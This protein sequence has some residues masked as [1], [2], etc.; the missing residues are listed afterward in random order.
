M[1]ERAQ[2]E[3]PVPL[4][5]PFGRQLE[6]RGSGPGAVLSAVVHGAL[7]GLLIWASGKR[8]VDATLAPG[9]GSGPRGG[10]GGGN[11]LAAIAV[12]LGGRPPAPPPPVVQQQATVVVPQHVDPLPTPPPDTTLPP[13]ADASAT[14]VAAAA[15]GTGAGPGVGPDSGSG[16]GGG[17]IFPPQPI[18]IIL[19]PPGRPGELRGVRVTVMF[20]VTERGVVD[21]V[22]VD[23]PIRDRGYRNEFMDRM[24]RYTFTPAYTP[25]GRKVAARFPFEIVL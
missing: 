2:S 19:P 1:N 10:G 6:R 20:Y 14:A 24:R 4:A 23:P 5:V 16:G 17:T 3:R 9:E 8:F 21:H 12:A 25:D 7:I 22:E 11:P 13:V 15:T 18:G